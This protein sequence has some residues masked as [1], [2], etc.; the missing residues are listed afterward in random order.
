M[1]APQL[2]SNLKAPDRSVSLA[3]AEALIQIDPEAA[4][5]ADVR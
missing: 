4:A 5:K 2:I 3:A 1:V